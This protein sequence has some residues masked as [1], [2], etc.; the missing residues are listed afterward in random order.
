MQLGLLDSLPKVTA[1]SG[2]SL[3]VVSDSVMG[4]RVLSTH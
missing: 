1:V 4:T 3:N 2:N